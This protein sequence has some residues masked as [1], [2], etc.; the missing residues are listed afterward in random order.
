[1]APPEAEADAPEPIDPWPARAVAGAVFVLFVF[2]ASPAH[3]WLDAGEI[4]AAG[5]ELGVMH[6][7][8]TP[9]LAQL[10]QLACALPV[11]HLGFRMSVMSAALA[12]GTVWM[13]A[14]PI[15]RRGGGWIAIVASGA[16]L[17]LGLTFS[18][19]A[20]LV[21]IYTYGSFLL[22][23][24]LAAFDPWLARARGASP[25]PR[26]STIGWRLLGVGAA[27]LGVWGFGDLRLA[28]ALPVAFAW[29]FALRRKQRWALHAPWVVVVASLPLLGLALASSRFVWADW[30]DPDGVR[31]LWEHAN[32]T[33]IRA[34][35]GS[36][37]LPTTW[38][39]WAHESRLA[40][41]RWVE[42]IGP[43][44][45]V[46]VVVAVGYL[47][48]DTRR[49]A[50]AAAKS[51]RRALGALLALFVVE[52][53]YVVGIN[54][55]GGI[56]R[57]TGVPLAMLAALVV[58]LALASIEV[59]MRPRALRWALLPGVAAL[60]W[61]SPGLRSLED[62]AATRSW[63]PHAWTRSALAQLPAGAAW[64]TVSD[65]M[66]AGWRAA[67]T[68]EGAR[69]DVAVYP[70]QHLY[71]SVPDAVVQRQ[72]DFAK[73]LSSA[74]G[75]CTEADRVVAFANAW[76]QPLF[77][78]NPGLDMVRALP[79][80]LSTPLP[81]GKVDLRATA[82]AV[83][84][85]GLRRI[86]RAALQAS[87]GN[88]ATPTD[89]RRVA[90][91]VS[92]RVRAWLSAN[93]DHPRAID[94]AIA[95]YREV[96]EHTGIELAGT[97]VSLGALVDRRGET[98][99]AI[100]LTRRALEVEPGRRLALTNL[101]LFLSRDPSTRVE[102]RAAAEAA[103]GLHPQRAGT[104]RR[105]AQVCAAMGDT[106]CV[107]RADARA[108]RAALARARAGAEHPSCASPK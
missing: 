51:E 69:P 33:S 23:T 64:L 15:Q 48:R 24:A 86:T 12:A 87:D 10:F 88:L 31:R 47:L 73:A 44:G 49:L 79:A 91:A 2:G 19:Q 56:D 53:I 32:A 99:K 83:D 57:Q 61:L 89:Q 8:G 72:P 21:E 85:A 55:M 17:A 9:G 62:F 75:G 63:G 13:L 27:V 101:A 30:G 41:G 104:W 58:G 39:P 105:L 3:A 76:R 25:S 77:V 102:A 90:Q 108:Q 80:D 65:D 107:E 16:W 46:S 54:P 93:P 52:W 28:F 71:R 1:M 74:Y 36:Q 4:A 92:A 70:S 50:G 100:A 29:L 18:R 45:P 7:T 40:F 82:E 98:Q 103:A 66:A 6:P 81:L 43:F 97:L 34:A 94:A 38:L 26:P 20:R 78:E 96:I 11:G 42:D 95:A 59:R 37:I 67:Q 68:L 14:Q 5:A 60:L 106:A 84:A 35:F 22:A